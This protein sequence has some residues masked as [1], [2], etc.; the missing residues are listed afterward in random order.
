ME[1]H[2]ILGLGSN[3]DYEIEWDSATMEGLIRS[4]AVRLDELAT[5]IAVESEGD[6]V[7]SVL[8]FVRDGAG[9][10]RFVTSPNV[11]E[12]FAE[13]F[14]KRITLGGTGPRAALAM[15]KLG[16]ASTVHL[17]SID[18]QIRRLLPPRVSYLCSARHDRT[19]P[20]L[21]VQFTEGSTLRA[22]DIEL[23]AP[24]SNRIIYVNDPANAKLALAED[25]GRA[26]A[27]ADVFLISG[28]NSI[29]DKDTLRTRLDELAQHLRSSPST[30]AV[31]YEDAGFHVPTHRTLVRKALA[32]Q[33][34]VYSMNEDEMQAH[35]ARS[36]NFLDAK[37]VLSALH[38]LHVVVPART[39][40]VHTSRW[41]LAFGERANELRPAL[42]AGLVMSGAR[43]VHGDE[44]TEADYLVVSRAPVNEA[45]QAFA[46][47]LERSTAAVCC[48][49]TFRLHPDRPTTIGLGD[50]F[51]GGFVAA[52]S[53]ASEA[54]S[55]AL[56]D[57]RGGPA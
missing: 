4:H 34:D 9:G 33:V 53:S 23:R 40:V 52:L 21:I 6:L 48:V 26:L 37:A 13:R 43:Y 44:F 39:L 14:S 36:V 29:S 24:R 1:R 35:L 32:G 27:T 47:G 2:L 11:I 41:A 8:A 25:L 17:V 38:E 56:L 5:S 51:V 49:P 12:T 7:R 10:E 42:R 57:S 22:G 16:V 45:G 30:A 31:I 54:E 28:L 55:W 20:H 18:N 50:A 3:I 46:V 15:D 19:Y